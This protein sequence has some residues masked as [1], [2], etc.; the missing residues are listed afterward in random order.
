MNANKPFL[1]LKTREAIVKLDAARLRAARERTLLGLALVISR[2]QVNHL[3]K[4]MPGV[5]A[6]AHRLRAESERHA[7]QLVVE[8]VVRYRREPH[9]PDSARELSETLRACVRVFPRE[10]AVLRSLLELD[11]CSEGEPPAPAG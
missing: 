1:E 4:P 2:V 8:Q 3:V 7:A 6:A 5:R 11:G 10:A 9:S